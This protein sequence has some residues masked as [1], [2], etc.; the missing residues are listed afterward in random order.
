[1][2]GKKNVSETQ[3]IQWNASLFPVEQLFQLFIVSQ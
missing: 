3:F 1:M 2:L